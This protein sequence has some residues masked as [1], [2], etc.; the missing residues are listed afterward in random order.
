MVPSL[1][2]SH[3]KHRQCLGTRPLSS[4]SVLQAK[5]TPACG[6]GSVALRPAMCRSGGVR[7]GM[8]IQCS[9]NPGGRDCPLPRS[10]LYSKLSTLTIWSFS[11]A[12]VWCQET[13]HRHSPLGGGTRPGLDFA[14]CPGHGRAPLPPQSSQAGVV[15]GKPSL[16]E[17]CKG[18]LTYSRT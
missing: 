14:L 12:G 17:V 7:S 3:S 8:G 5:H 2:Q 10:C 1:V 16:L 11:P 15:S 13:N 9:Y 6:R 18:D 4:L